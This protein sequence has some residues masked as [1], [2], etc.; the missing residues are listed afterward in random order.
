LGEHKVP[1]IAVNIIL[2]TVSTAISSLKSDKRVVDGGSQKM[3]YF[4]KKVNFIYIQ[5]AD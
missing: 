5:R 4:Y 2:Q 3:V 1:Y